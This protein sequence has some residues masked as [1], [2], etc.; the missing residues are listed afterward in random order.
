MKLRQDTGLK[1]VYTVGE[2]ATMAGLE[3]RRMGR[4]LDKAGVSYI[5]VGR[6]RMVAI[7]ELQKKCGS[8]WESSKLVG[9]LAGIEREHQES[10]RHQVQKSTDHERL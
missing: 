4:L 8:L 2:L 7:S 6:V 5:T 3:R 9:Y 1:A 10:L